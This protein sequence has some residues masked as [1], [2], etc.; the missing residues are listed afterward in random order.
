[1]IDVD[2]L[3][4]CNCKRPK[5]IAAAWHNADDDATC[6]RWTHDATIGPYARV[7]TRAMPRTRDECAELETR[8]EDGQPRQAVPVVTCGAYGTL[9]T[10]TTVHDAQQRHVRS[11]SRSSMTPTDGTPASLDADGCEKLNEH[12][13]CATDAA[14]TPAPATS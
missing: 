1:M 4:G 7:N 14:P 3:H 12:K 6:A 9:Q 11:D 10:Q 2:A 13:L 8:C 5:S